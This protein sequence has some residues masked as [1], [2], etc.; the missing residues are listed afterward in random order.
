[1]KNKKILT[2][3]C[4]VGSIIGLG[5]VSP[6]RAFES[7]IP[8]DSFVVRTEIGEYQG[9]RPDHKM[10]VTQTLKNGVEIRIY[11]TPEG[12]IDYKTKYQRFSDG[13]LIIEGDKGGNGDIDYRITFNNDGSVLYENQFPD[14]TVKKE[15]IK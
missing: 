13:R 14:G 7:K 6:V 5:Y 10:V 3:A 9:A 1:M 15:L 8:T 11:Y 12:K 2:L 4:I